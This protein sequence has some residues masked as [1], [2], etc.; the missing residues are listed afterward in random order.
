VIRLS[1]GLR[2]SMLWNYGLRD[3]M[4]LGVIDIYEGQ[5]PS[6]PDNPPVGKLLARITQDG[7]D[8]NYGFAQGGLLTTADTL[9]SLKHDGNWQLKGRGFGTPG[10]W[11]WK[12]NGGDDDQLSFFYPRVDGAVGDSLKNLPSQ[13]TPATDIAG[14]DFKFYFLNGG[15]PP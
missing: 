14:I 5:Q 13:I 11:R 4:W 3:L 15:P 8:F 6:I 10:W 9:V 12:W 2:A 7:L 1:T